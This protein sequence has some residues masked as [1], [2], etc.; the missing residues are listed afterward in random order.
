VEVLDDVIRGHLPPSLED[1][2]IIIRDRALLRRI[3]AAK[4]YKTIRGPEHSKLMN[5]VNDFRNNARE[6]KEVA[7]VNYQLNCCSC[8]LDI[9]P[10]IYI[11]DLKEEWIG[12]PVEYDDTDYFVYSYHGYSV[13]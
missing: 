12:T 6:L 3:R 5:F 8:I 2:P 7:S 11:E 1:I 4:K 9:I 10:D 13:Y